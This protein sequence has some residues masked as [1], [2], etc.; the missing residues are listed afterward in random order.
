MRTPSIK[1]RFTILL[2]CVALGFI[3]YGAWSIKLLR[4]VRVTG[5]IYDRIVQSKDLVADILPPPEYIIESYLVAFQLQAS[6][7]PAEQERL[8]QRM[9]TLQGEYDTRHKFW[10]EQALEPALKQAFLQD[11]HTPAQAFY[12]V[13]QQELLPAIRKQDKDAVA[14][15]MGR[16][17]SHYEQ[18]RHAIDRVVEMANKRSAD[19]EAAARERIGA[20]G[21]QMPAIL[22]LS[23]AAGVGVALHILRRRSR[24][25]GRTGRP[26]RFRRPD[27]ADPPASRRQQQPA[28]RDAGN[29]RQPGADRIARAQRH[30]SHLQRLVANRQ[31][32]P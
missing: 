12:G 23:L 17:R 19:D 6:A 18:H 15:A 24:R 5:P 7:D 8:Q 9:Q 27:R 16:L 13:V 31:R 11:A 29:A 20:A 32:Q 22:L 30:R 21:W 4:E 3:I 25:R 1:A 2:A 26:Y 14:A 10:L 28:A